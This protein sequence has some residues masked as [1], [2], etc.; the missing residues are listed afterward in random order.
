MD[1]PTDAVALGID[2]GG[3]KI[4][5][6]VGDG[7]GMLL[8]RDHRVT[9]S[10]TGRE[11]V[12]EAI[13][14]SVRHSLDEASLRMEQ[15]AA[16]GVGAPGP[17]NPQTGILHSSPNLPGWRDVPVQKLI[18]ARY[19]RPTFL[20]NDA[21]AAALAEY[22]FGAGR[23]SCC[24][25]YV[26]V[27]TGIGGG[28]VV[29]GDLYTGNQGV[30]AEIGHMTISDPGPPC[31]CGNTGCWEAMGS[32]TA[33]AK[34]ARRRIAAGDSTS[35]LDHA[36]GD[37]RKVTARTVQQAAEAGDGLAVGLVAETAHIIGTGLANLIN[38]FNPD[39]IALGGGLTRMG[40]MLLDPACE[41][42]RRR[43]FDPAVES[44]RIETAELGRNSGV[45]GAVVHA[46]GQVAASYNRNSMPRV[47]MQ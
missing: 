18:E 22:H 8:S 41:V 43:A 12:F 38:I 47:P 39:V 14:D 25:L 16:I 23:G 29:G 5:T 36:G 26:T 46:L 33:L 31:N 7:R 13:H 21:N 27:S 3:T 32:G 28:I 42:A 4:L 6:A 45:L 2:L 20:V 9:P 15:V 1:L 34:T 37:V 17:S 30:A 35:I 19:D 40:G 11:A 24:F 10:A 44:V